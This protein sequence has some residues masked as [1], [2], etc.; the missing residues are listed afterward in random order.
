MKKDLINLV[1]F[2]NK[3]I[4]K[5]C[6]ANEFSKYRSYYGE[7]FALASLHLSNNLTSP[8]K[9]YLKNQFENLDQLD[10]EFHFEF[11][12]Y[13]LLTNGLEQELTNLSRPLKFKGTTCTNWT[14]L[15]ERV[16][17]ELDEGF[18]LNNV[19]TKIENFQ[20]DSGLI[21]DDLGVK[22]FQ[23]HCFSMAMI[24]E[25]SLKLENDFLRESFRKGVEFIV[26][27]MSPTGETLFVGRGQNQSFGYSALVYILA[28]SSKVLK[29]NYYDHIDRIVS[30]LNKEISSFD[31]LPLMLNQRLEKPYLM[32][33]LDP[34]FYGWYPYNN[35]ID[36]FCFS[37]FFLTKALK[38]IS[39]SGMKVE[40]FADNYKD[41]DFWLVQNKK[42]FSLLSRPGGYWTN[43]LPF[44]FIQSKG[45]NITG[46][47]GGEQFQDSLYHMGETPLPINKLFNTS[48]RKKCKSYFKE[49]V[50]HV[51]SPLGILKREF[52]FLEDRITI[53]SNSFPSFLFKT[54]YFFKKEFQLVSKNTLRFEHVEITCSKEFRESGVSHTA[55]GQSV[56]YLVEGNHLMEIR[57]L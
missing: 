55:S 35:Y 48:I 26:N 19:I 2:L 56:K 53:Q 45:M 5:L 16:K 31:D 21:L 4:M 14:L 6:D 10:P 13:A 3:K 37:S 27:F 28:L 23:Y 25:M 47:Y 30:L 44:P 46:L 29:S 38:T 42:Y 7:S 34:A 51:L 12:N 52:D 54:P 33:K 39:E 41:K 24:G 8:T 17:L 57:F 49:N 36:Y 50:L 22:S 43:D 9:K 11:N 1:E 40:L 18:N 20:L 15:R 32:D